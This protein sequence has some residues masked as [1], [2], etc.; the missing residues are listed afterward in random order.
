MFTCT[1]RPTK[2]LCHMTVCDPRVSNNL[3]FPPPP[4]PTHTCTH[5][6]TVQSTT[7]SSSDA[8]TESTALMAGRRG[9][10]PLST[11]TSSSSGAMR[12]GSDRYT[13]IA[14]TYVGSCEVSKAVGKYQEFI[15]VGVCNFHMVSTPAI[16][17]DDTGNQQ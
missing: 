8:M 10:S 9:R 7:S 1:A 15:T 16:R 4:P 17:M 11:N 14:C 5:T 3:S 2:F 12:G 6:W 13:R